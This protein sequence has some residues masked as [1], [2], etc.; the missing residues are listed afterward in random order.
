MANGNVLFCTAVGCG[1]EESHM[2]QLESGLFSNVKRPKQALP[3]R[4]PEG[5]QQISP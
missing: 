4:A 3:W 5:G 1:G 2:L